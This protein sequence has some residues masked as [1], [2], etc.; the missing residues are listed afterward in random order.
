[1]R[2]CCM[3]QVDNS[4]YLEHYG[5]LGMKWGVRKDRKSGSSTVGSS[6]VE[7][8]KGLTDGQK[9]ALKI[10]AA[11]AVT[12]L[13][14]Y[15]GYRMVQA[16]PR[17][18]DNGRKFVAQLTMQQERNMRTNFDAKERREFENHKLDMSRPSK[19]TEN[20]TMSRKRANPYRGTPEGKNIC[21]NAG[22]AGV[23]RHSH[24]FEVTAKPVENGRQQNLGDTV[25]D[26]FDGA[27][28]LEGSAG[29]FG[30]S[31][32]DAS[33]MLKKRFGDNAAGV[34]SFEWRKL[35]PNE[36]SKG[37]TISW[38]IKNGN[39]EFDD[40]A[41][42][43]DNAGTAAYWRRMDANGGLIIARL[44]DAIPKF[45]NLKKYVDFG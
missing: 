26:C 30:K 2:G 45:E 5:V 14:A 16:N 36:E 41:Q 17:T 29:K 1:M 19:I 44:D 22:I 18:V 25:R 27:R 42:G 23:L 15:G 6:K 43:T 3:Q 28:I 20:K 40:Y 39:V 11:V 34:A 38:E 4:P 21:S 10:G 8:H 35:T 37:H 32:A 13:V 31:Q 7:K 9:R 24:G 12:A 33:D